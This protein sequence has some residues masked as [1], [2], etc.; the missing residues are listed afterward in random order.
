MKV[1]VSELVSNFVLEPIGESYL[2]VICDARNKVV[3]AGHFE[4]LNDAQSALNLMYTFK[5]RC[6]LTQKARVKS[7]VRADDFIEDFKSTIANIFPVEDSVSQ[8]EMHK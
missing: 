4:S 2:L 7:S 5:L 6:G 1:D 8:S 3:T